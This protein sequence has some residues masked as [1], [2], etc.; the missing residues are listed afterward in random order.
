M[1]K[2]I[3]GDQKEYGPVTTDELRRWITEGRLSGQSLVQSQ[4]AGDWK[5][6]A[7]FAEFAEALRLQAGLP[8]LAGSQVAPLG[9]EAWSAQILARYP[10]VQVGRC[11]AASWKLLMANFGLFFGA[12]FLVWLIS[13]VCQFIPL[14]GGLA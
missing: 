11:L 8:P 1:Y 13:V 14:L 9:A 7:T 5:P 6:L 2:I 10:E 4:G 3:G 12:T